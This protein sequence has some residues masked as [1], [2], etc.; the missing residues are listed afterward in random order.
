[1]TAGPA[2][3]I[4]LSYSRQDAAIAGKM[5]AALSAAGHDV[6]W[7]QALRSGEAYDQV[8]ETALRSALV[9]VVLWS[10]TAVASDWVRAEATVA[11]Q[12][13]VLMPVIIEPC[14][15]PVSFE[16]RQSADLTGWKGNGQDPRL[17]AFV[18]EVSER[19]GAAPAA[20][21]PAIA[22]SGPSR[23]LLIGGAAGVAALAAGGFGAWT[24][25]GGKADDGTASVVV[26]PFANLSGDAGQAFFS[27]GIAEELRNALSQIRGLKVIGRVSSETF[28]DTDDLPAAAETLGVDYVLTGSVRRSPTTIRIAAQL[29]DGRTGVESWSQSYDQPVGDALAIQSKIATSVVAALSAKL[30]RAAGAIIVGGTAN[31]QAQEL[32]LKAEQLGRAGQSKDMMDRQLVL[33]NEATKLD[34]DYAEAWALKGNIIGRGR[35]YSTPK[36]DDTARLAA[37][38]AASQRAVMLAP[39]SGY[40]HMSLAIRY[41]SQLEM[42]RAYVEAEKALT[43]APSDVRVIGEAGQFL[44][45]FDPDR[46][47]LLMQRAVALDPLNPVFLAAHSLALVAARRYLDGAVS[48]RQAMKISDNQ[49]GPNVL[50]VALFCLG[51]FDEAKANLRLIVVD[52]PRIT[53]TAAIEARVGTRA[54]SDAALAAIRSITDSR[55]NFNV[56]SIHAQ[57]GETAL[58]LEAL[59]ASL[60]EREGA[61]ALISTTPLFDPIRSEPRFKAV[62]DAVIPPDL[63]VP[64]K[65]GPA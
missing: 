42:R 27:D 61:L 5:A 30:G 32:F 58:A 37:S 52:L 33:L 53:L 24:F 54:A 16:L 4:F 57:R 41:A 39:T 36:E 56:A 55:T 14:Q 28:R 21:A 29:V 13:G 59:E 35:S 17:L 63:F 18:A 23:R 7:D 47:V 45:L 10:K 3:D 19:L 6:W 38:I 40:A 2:P 25:L 44:R 46:A 49:Y 8:I 64:P 50:V 65:R 60:R 11:L 22:S 51:R 9:V 34:P 12:R 15:R 31:A 26:L 1:M 62:Q 43:L 20:P 48:A